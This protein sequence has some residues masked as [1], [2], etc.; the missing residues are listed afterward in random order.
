MKISASQ[1]KKPYI[2]SVVVSSKRP[3]RNLCQII[4]DHWK[5]VT[6]VESQSVKKGPCLEPFKRGI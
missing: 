6:S 2:R 3:I 5:V 1:N 4:D